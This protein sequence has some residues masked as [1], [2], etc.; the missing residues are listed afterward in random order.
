LCKSF[1]VLLVFQEYYSTAFV[2][3]TILI[4]LFTIV[5]LKSLSGFNRNRSVSPGVLRTS[6]SLF[7]L[8]SGKHLLI[9]FDYHY[10][11]GLKTLLTKEDVSV[12]ILYRY[13]LII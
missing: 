6:V 4:Y 3:S 8:F 5:Y 1:F 12:D 13:V 11:N 2:F 9:Q 7:I 10:F